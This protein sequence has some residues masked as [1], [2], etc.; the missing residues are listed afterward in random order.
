MLS[1]ELN[2][3]HVV[4]TLLNATIF[5]ICQELTLQRVFG[6]MSST[7]TALS[8]VQNKRDLR[9]LTDETNTNTLNVGFDALLQ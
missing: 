2:F 7:P 5:H 8:C 4:S 6:H 3:P 9:I 1:D